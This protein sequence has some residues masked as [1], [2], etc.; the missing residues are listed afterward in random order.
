MKLNGMNNLLRETPAPQGKGRAFSAK[1]ENKSSFEEIIGQ[2]SEPASRVEKRPDGSKDKGQEKNLPAQPTPPALS[3]PLKAERFPTASVEPTGL[4]PSNVAFPMA[5]GSE[6]EVDGLTR[7]VVWNDFL[8]KLK[9]EFGVTAEDV[10]NAF[11]SLSAEELAQP[12]EENVDKVVMALGLDPQAAQVA[13]QYFNELL[14][15]TQPK[16]LGAELASS[17]RQ[18]NLTLMTQR[19]LQQRKTD[20]RLDQMQTDFFMKDQ[21]QA[22]SVQKGQMD[23]LAPIVDQMQ[24]VS[25]SSTPD[26]AV[27]NLVKNFM[28]AQ[29]PTA[30]AIPVTEMPPTIAPT[31][32]ANAP[33]SPLGVTAPTV[34]PI[35]ERFE[36][37]EQTSEDEE[38]TSDASFL[39]AGITGDSTVQGSASGDFKNTLAQA[40]PGAT[41]PMAVS[42]IVSQAQVMVRDGGG[43]MKV[44]LNQEGLGEVAMRVNVD[45]GKVSVQMVTES[46]EAKRLIDRH[47][48][49]LKSSLSANNLQVESIK[50]DTASD[51]GKQLDQQYQDAQRQA[52]HQAMEQFRQ[53]HQGWRRSFFEVPGVRN[54]KGQTEGPRD[55]QPPTD[56]A[57]RAGSRRLDLVA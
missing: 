11:S 6:P 57:R 28:S 47:L 38:F 24:A 3:R 4:A 48:V 31:I 43:E 44:K 54:Y 42:D 10:L 19:E 35:I 8:R 23:Q 21:I 40:A 15:K 26:A 29:A 56:S 49:D 41:Q 50:I 37:G 51:I 27:D 12:P 39:S 36:N 45:Q 55:V 13:K 14:K 17:G 7:R 34:A 53:D 1:G 25:E 9:E 33:A 20:R 5:T 46:D 16:S 32:K 52:A 2:N 18:I 22:P 30:K